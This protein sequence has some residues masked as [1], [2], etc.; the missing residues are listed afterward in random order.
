[1]CGDA[2]KIEDVEKLM[3]GQKADMVFTDPPYNVNYQSAAGNGY[4]EGKYKHKKI[5]NDNLSDEQFTQFLLDAGASIEIATK[6]DCP[7]YVWHGD[8]EYK[9]I[10]FYTMFQKLGWH[11]SSS[12]IWSKESFSMGWQHYKS[13]H[14]VC[15]YGWKG[16]TPEFYSKNA[17]TIW[18]IQRSLTTSYEH[19]TSKP[20]ALC[21]KGINN[22]SKQDDIVLDLF[23]GSGSALIASEQTNRTCYM[24]ELDP[25]YCDA[26]RKRYANIAGI[27]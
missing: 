18:S 19:P 9:A 20:I 2:T 1:M 15:S 25:R 22:S 12:I 10:P 16:K 14:E 27:S 24:M 3:D 8:L 6:G 7:I 21:S 26:I 17:S 13:Q 5:F 11:R 23:G 4:S